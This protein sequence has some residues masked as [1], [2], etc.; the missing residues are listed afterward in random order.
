[1]YDK[2]E[3]APLF[4]NPL[5]NSLHLPWRIDIEWHDNR[6]FD[7]ARQ[8]FDIFPGFVVDVSYGHFSAE[9]PER[10][11]TASGNRI[12]VGNPD[13]QT[14]ITLEELGFH[15]RKHCDDFFSD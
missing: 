1:M 8:R 2:I 10:F 14:S 11:G 13:D 12:F 5:K 15:C 6:C 9:R 3:C 7:L 4:G